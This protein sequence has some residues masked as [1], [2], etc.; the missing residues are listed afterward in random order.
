MN[1]MDQTWKG[2]LI[3]DYNT[4]S[5]ELPTKCNGTAFKW[6]TSHSTK[7]K[8]C[9]IKH[10]VNLIKHLLEFISICSLTQVQGTKSMELNIIS[11]HNEKMN[12]T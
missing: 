7:S 6:I 3:S 4:C 1:E 2:I 11:R 9:L 8:Y 10:N 12:F 5:N